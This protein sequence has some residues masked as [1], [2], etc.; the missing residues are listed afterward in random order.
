MRRLKFNGVG[1]IPV[2]PVPGQPTPTAWGVGF[3][4]VVDT[5]LGQDGALY[6]VKQYSSHIA[7][8]LGRIRG[9]PTAQL[10][11]IVSGDNQTGNAGRPLAQP[12][13]VHVTDPTG[14]PMTGQV[15]T[16]AVTGG[17]TVNPPFALT[18]SQ[19]NAATN[20]T[21]ASAYSQAPVITATAAGTSYVQFH[22]V[23][24]G[25]GIAY[26]PPPFNTITAEVR[27]SQTNSPF[28]LAFEPPASSP[29]LL[30]PFGD[31]WTSVIAPGSGLQA[32]DG[33]GLIGPAN[34]GFRTGTS[35]PVW[36]YTLANLPPLGG[37]TLLFQGYAIDT[38]LYPA[39]ESIMISN[40]QIVT[41]L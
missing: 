28:T 38:A 27:H 39:P 7:G 9:D 13:V 21:L 25:I 29:Y 20:Y 16:F 41:I 1:W 37:V 32:L 11:T 40:T 10:L 24:R 19:G 15:V 4:S 8:A 35:S 31:V 14:A 26:M 6:Y 33:L 30:T 36:F 17:G 5:A 34:P 2:P 22:V 23:W 12:F 18:D 3:Q